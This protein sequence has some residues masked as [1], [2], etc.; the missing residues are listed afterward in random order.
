MSSDNLIERQI[1]TAIFE[2]HRHFAELRTEINE[3]RE[4]LRALANIRLVLR[5]NVSSDDDESSE[6]DSVT[7]APATVSYDR[8]SRVN[9]WAD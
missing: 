1:L 3:M 4:D 2:L 6:C 9:D 8:H 7:S 5:T